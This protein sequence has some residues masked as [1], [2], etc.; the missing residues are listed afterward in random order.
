MYGR[1]VQFIPCM[2]RNMLLEAQLS[3]IHRQRNV[4]LFR[5]YLD[6]LLVDLDVHYGLAT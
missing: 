2:V 6:C 1:M 4:Q 5:P 3:I